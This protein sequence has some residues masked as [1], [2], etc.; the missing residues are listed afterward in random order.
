VGVTASLIVFLATFSAADS[1]PADTVTVSVLAVQATEE[2]RSAK[3][4]EST[5]AKPRK[6][7]GVSEQLRTGFVSAENGKRANGKK[8]HFDPGLEE[9]RDAVATFPYDTYRKVSSQ[10]ATIERNEEKRIAVNDTYTLYLTA[11][12]KDGEDRLRVR[13]RIDEKAVRGGKPVTINALDTTSAIAPGKHLML[14]GLPLP[15]G[16][17]I[18][19]ISLR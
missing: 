9:I 13:V 12:D 16:K 18:V 15:E 1:K 2:G 14:G 4:D 6:P 5:S 11:L 7:R 19:F 8:S 3:A 17:L 10:T